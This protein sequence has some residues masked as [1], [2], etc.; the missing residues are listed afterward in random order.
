[1]K[2]L[3]AVRII[4]IGMIFIF[5]SSQV[6]SAQNQESILFWSRYNISG[7]S[8]ERFNTNSGN[9]ETIALSDN[10]HLPSDITLDLTHGKMYWC[11]S[12][13]GTIM[14]ANVDGSSPEVIIAG[15]RNPTA[16]EL[17]VAGGKIYWSDEAD[18][19][20]QQANLDGTEVKEILSN[21]DGII[22]FAI[23]SA[24]GYV[25][26]RTAGTISRGAFYG[27]ESENFGTCLQ[28]SGGIIDLDTTNGKVYW[29]TVYWSGNSGVGGI[30]ADPWYSQ[31]R[32]A[33]IDGSGQETLFNQTYSLSGFTIDDSK[34]KIYFSN[35]G[36]VS[37]SDLDLLN[38]EDIANVDAGS[39]FVI[40][41]DNSIIYSS[42][43]RILR[44]SAD[45]S[46][47]ETLLEDPFFN[48]GG[49]A[50]DPANAAI[51]FYSSGVQY[52]RY[53]AIYRMNFDGTNITKIASVPK[54]SNA[55]SGGNIALDVVNGKIYW[56]NNNNIYRCNLNGSN[57]EVVVT[58]YTITTGLALDIVNGKLYWSETLGDYSGTIKRSNLDGTNVE[59]FLGGYSAYVTNIAIDVTA[60]KIYW[61][62][63][64]N[65]P[66][67]DHLGI[68]RANLDGSE[69][70]DIKIY[71]DLSLILMALDFNEGKLY[72][73]QSSSSENVSVHSSD[74]DGNN[75]QQY[76]DLNPKYYSAALSYQ[77][78]VYTSWN[79]FLNQENIVEIYNK[80]TSPLAVFVSLFDGSGNQVE[81]TDFMLNSYKQRDTILSGFDNFTTDSYGIVKIE[82][83]HSD[84]G[85]RVFYYK[86]DTNNIDYQFAFGLPFA[87]TLMGS[88]YVTFNTYNPT[89]NVD[90][91]NDLIAQWLS[92]V[93]LNKSGLKH[94]D[95]IRY[96][97]VGTVIDQRTISVSPYG[98][99]DIEGGHENPGPDN[100]GL[101]RVA[102]SDLT[103]PYIAQLVRYSGNAPVGTVPNNYYFAYP[104]IAQEGSNEVQYAP[105]ST[106]ANGVNW[107]EVVNTSQMPT[108]VYVELYDNQ[109]KLVG[110]FD[111]Y[112]ESH[113]QRHINVGERLSAGNSGIAI[114]RP[115]GSAAII[116][117]SMFYFFDAISGNVT[118]M[119]GTQAK[120][121]SPGTTLSGTYNLFL[122]NYNWLKVFNI[123]NERVS[124]NLSV[125]ADPNNPT[126]LSFELPPKS[127]RDLG[128]HESLAYGTTTNSYGVFKVESN[129]SSSLVCELLR[130]RPH[131]DG[132][133]IDY[134]APTEVR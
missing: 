31:I 2:N 25:F 45:G 19:N 53:S 104:L 51:Y 100:V 72:W 111:V 90:Q 67:V 93:N 73:S 128:L 6:V 134:T 41:A 27:A 68:A 14:R 78:V 121:I 62:Y 86:Q 15:L 125:Y 43:G 105:I 77:S 8:I 76:L 18:G 52:G 46:S 48:L 113:G 124:V 89:R 23:D 55:P 74:L 63:G 59:S 3:K 39:N 130:I 110:A 112:L 117:Q 127:G 107:L 87:N 33:N 116:A 26:W 82:L 42:D 115:Q 91:Q 103:S 4:V 133:Y 122:N 49:L 58:R 114:L 44:S 65:S 56:A 50:T 88:S 80:T 29:S 69:I 132:A 21:A 40:D 5:G 60:N 7:D 97:Q 20:V 22:D 131:S 34:A 92:I 28:C 66:L 98:R 85:G 9:L 109:G 57:V 102:P 101:I 96:D 129:K 123:S 99:R 94:F 12:L 83:S 61:S 75:E 71:N 118:S 79:H 30:G 64:A 126:V 108:E 119:Y 32:R 16:I 120:T 11:E 35:S 37:Q 13:K 95:V 81:Q 36:T 17:D 10:I 1:M 47:T 106:G 70:E 54:V 38:V 84:N 24:N